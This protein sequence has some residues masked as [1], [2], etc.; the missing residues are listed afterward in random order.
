MRLISPLL[1]AMLLFPACGGDSAVTT[2]RVGATTAAVTPAIEIVVEGVLWELPGTA[3]AGTHEDIAA[4]AATAAAEVERLVAARVSGWPTTTVAPPGDAA[5]FFVSVNRVG[6]TALALGLLAG[7][8]AAI[9]DAWA[10]FEAGY[11]GAEWEPV[12]V[13]AIRLPGWQATAAAIAAAVTSACG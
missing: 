2:D 6:P 8:E 5:T 9:Q 12:D 10:D 1:A 3:C 13:I 4:A 7:T 11:A